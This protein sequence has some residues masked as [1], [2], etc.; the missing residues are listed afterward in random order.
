MK[1]KKVEKPRHIPAYGEKGVTAEQGE[2]AMVDPPM[3]TVKEHSVTLRHFAI[4]GFG[5][6][7]LHVRFAEIAGAHGEACLFA[8]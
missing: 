6:T 2:G 3:D 7:P 4:F 5:S 8:L 1:G